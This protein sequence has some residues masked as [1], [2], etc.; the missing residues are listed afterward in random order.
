MARGRHSIVVYIAMSDWMIIVIS[1]YCS[2]EICNG[3]CLVQHWLMNELTLQ[4]NMIGIH[5]ISAPAPRLVHFWC[6]WIA[7]THN[8]KWM[9]GI[10]PGINIAPDIGSERRG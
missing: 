8:L 3:Y 9:S 4:A 7:K 6:A 1:K 2:W 10:F 5:Q